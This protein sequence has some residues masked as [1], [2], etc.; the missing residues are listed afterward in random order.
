MLIHY[1]VIHSIQYF[2]L[3]YSIKK[4]QCSHLVIFPWFLYKYPHLLAWFHFP[5]TSFPENS[6]E[7]SLNG[8]VFFSFSN[9]SSVRLVRLVEAMFTLGIQITGP[10]IASVDEASWHVVCSLYANRV[11][12]QPHIWSLLPL[13]FIHSFLAVSSQKQLTPAKMRH[14][15]VKV[16]N[17]KWVTEHIESRSLCRLNRY[18]QKCFDWL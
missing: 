10:C 9:P 12:R 11:S 18:V 13:F 6:K 15:Q 1:V 5:P 8:K 3:H 14:A 4:P 16:S 7:V 2:F 17:S